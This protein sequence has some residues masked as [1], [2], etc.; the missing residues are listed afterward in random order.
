MGYLKTIAYSDI[1]EVIEYEKSPRPIERKKRRDELPTQLTLD[2]ND[3]QDPREQSEQ[4]TPR[5][6]KNIKRS[7]M[8]L[9]R[10]IQANL[11]PTSRPLLITLTYAENMQEYQQAREDLESFI[12]NL[13]F[14]FPLLRYVAVAEY[15]KRGAIHY[16]TLIWGIPF[17]MEVQ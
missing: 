7:I 4:T 8:G 14:S 5:Q 17:A 13:R 9:R 1:L 3:R 2:L 10:L 6:K 15:Q 16:H 12:S 11:S